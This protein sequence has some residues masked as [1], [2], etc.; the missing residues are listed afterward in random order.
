MRAPLILE[1][2]EALWTQLAGPGKQ[3]L[4]PLALALTTSSLELTARL[5]DR[6]RAVAV[7]V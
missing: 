5:G 6:H 2:E 1:R 3:L 4:V 7:L